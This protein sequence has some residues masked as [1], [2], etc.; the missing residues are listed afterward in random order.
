MESLV[1]FIMKDGACKLGLGVGQSESS[2][3]VLVKP[4]NLKII[5]ITNQIKNLRRN[6]LHYII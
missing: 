5:I 4:I 2:L 6:D 3:K 1:N